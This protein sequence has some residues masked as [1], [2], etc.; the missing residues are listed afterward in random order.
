MIVKLG[1]A[2]GDE[3]GKA[4]GGQAGDQTG[5]EV[6]VSNWYR[7]DKVWRVF[8][9]R[10]PAQ[11]AMIAKDCEWA[12]ENAHIGYD[13]D[14]R[15]TLYKAAQKV[16]FNCA[17]VDVDCETDCSAL[18]RVCCAYAGIMLPNFNT[19]TEP[20]VLLNSGEFVELTGPKYSDSSDY[21]RRG[22]ILCTS[23]QGH[24]AIVLTNG[25]KVD[26]DTT[27]GKI[28]LG[29]RVLKHGDVG[30]DVRE[31]QVGLISLG[32]DCG[33][34]GADGDFGD[35]TEMAVKAFQREHPPLVV[36]GEFGP[37]SLAALEK[38][39]REP[40]EEPENPR[41]VEIVGGNCY[42]RAAPNTGGKILGVATR[43]SRWPYQGETSPGGWQLVEY[44]V[45]NGWISGKYGRLCE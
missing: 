5:R 11:A 13:Q 15:L 8:R 34:W 29:D 2:R 38:A 7:H 26:E 19:T 33:T 16:G 4:R 17:H 20:K 25:A 6:S 45:Q 22:D 42:V 18:V 41:F 9:P 37:K 10:T 39:L 35:A 30:E 43:G 3:R 28:H 32:Y 12:C 40:E 31:M 1:H 27:P 23:V 14:E 21:L 36:D 24:T 44:G